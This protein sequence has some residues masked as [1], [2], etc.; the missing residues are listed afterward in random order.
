MKRGM[1]LKKTSEKE[2]QLSVFRA[3]AFLLVHRDRSNEAEGSRAAPH[4]KIKIDDDLHPLE[5]RL[6]QRPRWEAPGTLE[7]GE[8][9]LLRW[10]FPQSEDSEIGAT[11][12]G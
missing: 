12:S 4:M 2:G 7:E 6:L 8:A 1:G 10:T 9:T 3:R 5:D 11:A